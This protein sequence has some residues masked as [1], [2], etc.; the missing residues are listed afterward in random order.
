MDFGGDTRGDIV[1]DTFFHTEDF[2][3]RYTH[4]RQEVGRGYPYP[5]VG[6]KSKGDPT[7]SS[8]INKM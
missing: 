6:Q 1:V 4:S 3:V 5:V 8:I 7:N 2:F